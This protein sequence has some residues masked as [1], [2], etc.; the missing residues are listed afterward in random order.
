[1]SNFKTS[2]SEEFSNESEIQVNFACLIFLM[3]IV[4]LIFV[5]PASI[6][7]I[8]IPILAILMGLFLYIKSPTKYL[9][10]VFWSWL[11][12]PFVSRMIEYR[13]GVAQDSFRLIIATPYILNFMMIE[14]FWNRLSIF[15]SAEGLPFAGAATSI[16]YSLLIGLANNYSFA[17]ISQEFLSWSSPILIGFFMLSN[18]TN[19]PKFKNATQITFILGTAVMGIYGIYQYLSP[20]IWDVFWWEHSENIQNASGVPESKLIRVWS[21]L[22]TPFIFSYT[23]S[24]CIMVTITKIK[25]IVVPILSIGVVALLLSQVRV[26]WIA[27]V[28]AL[29]IMFISSH[30]KI[31]AKL[32]NMLMFSIILIVPA[33]LHPDLSESIF[34]RLDTF[35]AG[36]DD[37]SF[38]ER[39]SIYETVM[40]GAL[41][42]LIGKGLGTPKIIDAGIADILNTLGWFG[43]LIMMS[44]IFLV[45]WKFFHKLHKD[46][47]QSISQAIPIA[48]LVTTPLNNT[49]ILLPGVLF[50]SFIG[51]F[52]AGNRYNRLISENKIVTQSSLR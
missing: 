45:F 38:Q 49:F 6:G 23:M 2:Y 42:Q 37:F 47:F 44:S 13:L 26:G 29:F 16:C 33:I 12:A 17:N 52:F 31:G 43:T 27:L 36:A 19:Y 50:W 32:F 30:P 15:I 8:A 46:S 3:S 24:V 20:P 1:M 4:G 22:N 48:L 5:V 35:S 18:W 39:Q 7:K 14:T 11:L 25:P 41:K 21:T 28:V 34:S 10:L 51:L 9:M 40:A